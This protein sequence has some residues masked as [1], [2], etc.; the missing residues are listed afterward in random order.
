[1]VRNATPSGTCAR[2]N[3][4]RDR[5]RRRV[6]SAVVMEGDKV[7]GVFTT[8]DA[9]SALAAMLTAPRAAS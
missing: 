9:L 5:E 3:S 4:A 6:G 7:I 1:L 2:Y 8:T